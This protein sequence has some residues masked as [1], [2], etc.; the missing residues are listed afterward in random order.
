MQK[1]SYYLLF[2]AIFIFSLVY[3]RSLSIFIQVSCL[4]ILLSFLAK[5]IV[6]I[7]N[8]DD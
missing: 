5:I 1:I 6:E 2:Q 3:F 7:V 8:F 4:I